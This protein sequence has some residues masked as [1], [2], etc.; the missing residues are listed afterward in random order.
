MHAGRGAVSSHPTCYTDMVSRD[1]WIESTGPSKRVP[2]RVSSAR[3]ATDSGRMR[4]VTI[5]PAPEW[6]GASA[7]VAEPCGH[8]KRT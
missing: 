4:T 7:G 1:P 5:R 6:V 2:L 8:T 3:S